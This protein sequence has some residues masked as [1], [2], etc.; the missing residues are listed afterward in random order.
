[1]EPSQPFELRW[2][3]IST[4]KI[5]RTFVTVGTFH[6][7]GAYFANPPRLGPARGPQKVRTWV[8]K[9]RTTDTYLVEMSTTSYTR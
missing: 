8:L 1:M 4:G 7:T 2:G 9:F 5:A 6:T 3:I